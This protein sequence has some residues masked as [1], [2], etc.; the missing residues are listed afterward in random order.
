[1]AARLHGLNRGPAEKKRGETRMPMDRDEVER[2]IRAGVPDADV[3]IE[4]LR[5]GGTP[6]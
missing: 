4:D 2:L 6:S 5:D 3:M 1:M